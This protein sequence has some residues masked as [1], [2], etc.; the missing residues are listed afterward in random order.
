M[1][2][3]FDISFQRSVLFDGSC[4]VK[5][6][7]AGLSFDQVWRCA[8]LDC[9]LEIDRFLLVKVCCGLLAASVDRSCMVRWCDCIGEPFA[10]SISELAMIEGF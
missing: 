1:L 7:C 9:Q 10:M 4:H 5:A 3:E 2:R 6:S 8:C